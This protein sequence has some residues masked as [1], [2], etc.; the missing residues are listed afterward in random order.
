MDG[1]QA[2]LEKELNHWDFEE[3]KAN[4][5]NI[6]NET[7]SGAGLKIKGGTEEQKT[8][9]YTALYHTMLFPCDFAD[10]DGKYIGADKQAHQNSDFTYRMCFSGWDVF[11]HQFPLLTIIRPDVVNDEVNSLIAMAEQTGKT[12]P[13]WEM[14]SDYTGCMIGDPGVSVVVDAYM[15]GIRNYDVEKAYEISRRTATGP[16][17]TRNNMAAFNTYGYVPGSVRLATS[18]T[19]ENAYADWCIGRFAEALGKQDDAD[20]FMKQSLNYKNIFDPSFGWMRRKDEHGQ[21]MEFTDKYTHGEGNCEANTFQQSWFVPHDVQG[22]IK[23]MGEEAF[24][25]NLDEFFEGAAANFKG[26][27]CYNHGNE[28]DH[29]VISLYNYIGQPWKT[30]YWTRE[31]LKR[32][33]G[34]ENDGLCG[35]DD[36]GQISAWYV[37]NAIGLNPVGPGD[38][39]WNIGSPIFEEI[40]ISLNPAY[41]SCTIASAFTITAK[42]NSAEDIY[43]QKATLNGKPLNRP[44]I[45]H[46]EII[47][48]GQ[49]VLVMGTEKS[50]WGSETSSVP[51][52]LS[53]GTFPTAIKSNNNPI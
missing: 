29:Q 33:Y 46:E 1:A 38:N 51:P 16:G 14:T 47:S 31:I 27:K 26:G 41:H 34:T 24:L 19:L 45:S 3:V 20:L 22:L 13:K 53:N 4:A 2:N 40:K 11:R 5:H 49:L 36:V 44:W 52:S 50:T 43:I 48:G 32:A 7:I 6:W 17:S 39:V 35:S 42:N 25:S 9:F 30:Q 15:K 8:I 21:W 18:V 28:P 23:L 12:Y 37:L 10:V